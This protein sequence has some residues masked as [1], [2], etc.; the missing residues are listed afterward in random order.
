MIGPAGEAVVVGSELSHV[1]GTG[2]TQTKALRDVSLS[3]TVGELVLLMGPS[4]SGKSTLLAALS[5][6]MRPD[7][8]RVWV[9][10][11]D[12][13][14]MSDPQRERFRLK[15]CGFVFQ[16]FNLF[17]S[18]TVGEQLEMVL[19]WGEPLSGRDVRQRVE[20][21]LD[22]L[23]VGGKRHLCPGALSGGE[24]QR[25]AIGRAL[26][27]APALMFADEPTSALDWAHG[28]QVM[29]LLRGAARPGGATVLVVSHDP[30][31]V[32]YADRVL[33]LEDG[34]LLRSP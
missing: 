7:R 6:L 33:S 23:G 32:P 18:L 9:L 5:G 15:H 10:G 22:L 20:K 11:Q 3:L 29:E 31:L 30:R 2:A 34:C 16:G 21:M 27:K 12:L 13:W 28:R 17:P 14:Q 24:K 8:G 26:I 19:R 25:V 4:G 1:F